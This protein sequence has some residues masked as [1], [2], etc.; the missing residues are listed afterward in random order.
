MIELFE[1]QTAL[2]LGLIEEAHGLGGML[3][4]EYPL[5]FE[6]EFSGHTLGVGEA[7]EMR[8]AC[9]FLVRDLALPSRD[10]GSKLRVGLI[11]SVTTGEAW[12]GQGFGT[13]LVIEAEA[14]LQLEGCAAVFLWA[15][16][17]RF[18]LRRGYAPVG[19][20]EDVLVPAVLAPKLPAPTDVRPLIPSDIAAVH[21]L[22][23]RHPA[24]VERTIEETAALI[25]C[26][27]MDALVREHDGVVVAY[28]LRGR[29]RD[30]AEVVHEWGGAPHHV[31]A[32]LRAHLER[33]FESVDPGALILMA[34]TS[35]K[36]LLDA[37]DAVGCSRQTGILGLGKVLDREAA[38]EAIADRLG[39]LGSAKVCMGIDEVGN[40]VPGLHLAGPSGECFLDDEATLALMF[41]PES[42][43]ESAHELT[44]SLGLPDT[45]LPLE[46]FFWGLDSI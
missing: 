20:E 30:L 38:A 5:V 23:S 44:L 13:R 11:G 33:R 16:D 46:P 22:Y 45:E 42:V 10:G 29:G 19:C 36:P 26:P 43:R 25:D 34:P 27:R 21:E 12:R 9:A 32:L 3:A 8:A 18:Y 37:L 28:A 1:D 6:D 31:L 4:P 17:P 35:E 14:R 15:D 40:E 41:A 39:V 24:R 2:A 7:G